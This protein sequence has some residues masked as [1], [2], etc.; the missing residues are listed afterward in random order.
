MMQ[1]RVCVCVWR[2]VAK[3]VEE[4]NGIIE[5]LVTFFR[6]DSEVTNIYHPALHVNN[7]FE[8]F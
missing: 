5:D 3:I 2:E 8:I 4:V 1:A 6:Y 7:Q